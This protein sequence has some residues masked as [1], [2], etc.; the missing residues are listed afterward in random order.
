MGKILNEQR[1]GN[2]GK[3]VLVV[4]DEVSLCFLLRNFLN[5]MNC[6]VTCEH[7]LKGAKNHYSNRKPDLIL[8][9]IHLP[10]GLGLELLEIIRKK[11]K[12]TTIILMSSQRD[13]GKA[14]EKIMDKA[15]FFLQKPF[16]LKEVEQVI[17]QYS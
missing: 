7:T 1:N 9:D 5:R 15:D 12:G 11:D 2:T 3:Q 16:Q 6:K 17:K 4:D 10:D 14:N 8:L 13:F